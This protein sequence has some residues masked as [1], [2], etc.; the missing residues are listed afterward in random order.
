MLRQLLSALLL[1][2]CHHV[3][4]GMLLF[5][6]WRKS[7]FFQKFILSQVLIVSVI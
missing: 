5:L 2:L 7:D 6:S 3:K 4:V 1:S